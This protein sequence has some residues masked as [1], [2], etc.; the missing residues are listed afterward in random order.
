PAVLT[1]ATICDP[2]TE[3]T[4]PIRTSGSGFRLSSIDG[5]LS[6][7]IFVLKNVRDGR[8]VRAAGG[9]DH[10]RGRSDSEPA[11]QLQLAAVQFHERSRDRQSEAG[12]LVLAAETAIH[13]D[14]RF[15]DPREILL[16]HPDAGVRDFEH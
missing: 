1:R 8:S 3:T 7:M 9:E 12:A 2:A 10:G 4:R 6:S 5:P 13:L 14:E 15:H 11:L 16:G